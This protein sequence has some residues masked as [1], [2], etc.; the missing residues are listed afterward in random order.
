MCFG[1]LHDP[2]VA[3]R[4]FLFFFFLIDAAPPYPGRQDTESKLGRQ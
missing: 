4:F 2:L 1:Q 3:D